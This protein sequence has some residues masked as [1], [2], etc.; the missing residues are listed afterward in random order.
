MKR[1]FPKKLSVSR[2]LLL[3][4]FILLTGLGL[5]LGLLAIKLNVDY[6]RKAETVTFKAAI[7][8]NPFNTPNYKE[9]YNK[10]PEIIAPEMVSLSSG[11]ILNVELLITDPDWIP[12]LEQVKTRFTAYKPLPMGLKILCLSQKKTRSCSIVGVPTTA[13]SEPQIL[14]INAT[15][16]F[17]ITIS[18]KILLR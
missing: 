7:P 1:L 9:L 4:Y 6:R 14:T 3:C 5:P 18:K 16:A 12:G 15:D 10:P 8:P 2:F 11:A 13:P 17:G